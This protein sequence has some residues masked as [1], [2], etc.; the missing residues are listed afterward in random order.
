MAGAGGRVQRQSGARPAS[1]TRGTLLVARRRERAHVGHRCRHGNPQR[2][3]VSGDMGEHRT[4]L[5]RDD[6][7]YRQVSRIGLGPQV[8]SVPHRREAGLKEVQPL[9][10]ADGKIVADF[11]VG[12]DQLP[13][14]RAV[15][16]PTPA[17]DRIDIGDAPA[18]HACRSSSVSS[19]P[20]RD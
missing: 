17:V 5:M 2:L 15:D 16:A 13:G 9:V 18:D 6:E 11:I 12:V 10:V 20:R 8:S 1:R 4:A 19:A 7:R 14:E 3:C